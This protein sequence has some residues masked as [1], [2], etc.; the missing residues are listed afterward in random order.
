M[1]L[2]HARAT[3]RLLTEAVKLTNLETHMRLEMFTKLTVLVK[4]D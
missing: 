4:E 1:R 2:Q 3:V